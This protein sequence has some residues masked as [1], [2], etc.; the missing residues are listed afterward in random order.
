M[1]LDT[2]APSVSK[3]TA[4]SNVATM[5]EEELDYEDEDA[6]EIAVPEKKRKVPEA[7]ERA[8]PTNVQSP[9]R[10]TC[11]WSSQLKKLPH[12][13]RGYVPAQHHQGLSGLQTS[14]SGKVGRMHTLA[15]SS[16]DS[17]FCSKAATICCSAD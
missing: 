2:S 7:G 16:R 4:A 17:V 8:Y 9:M 5:L 1:S 13:A 3:K 12:P 14:G 10:F 6:E 15:G 11:C